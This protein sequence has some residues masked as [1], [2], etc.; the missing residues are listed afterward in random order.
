MKCNI[1]SRCKKET[2]KFYYIKID[3]ELVVQHLFEDKDEKLDMQ[4]RTYSF[5]V[6]DYIAI[7][8]VRGNPIR[9]ISIN[10]FEDNCIC[11]NELVDDR[12]VE[13]DKKA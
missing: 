8:I 13:S 3:E 4:T 7:P 1:S 5:K 2:L 6:G 9:K 11:I 10:L 12:M